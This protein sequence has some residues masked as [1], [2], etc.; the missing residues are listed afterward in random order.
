[1]KKPAL[2]DGEW[3][4]MNLLWEKSPRTIAEMVAALKDDTAWTKATINIMLGRMI[5]KGAV[6][7]DDSGRSKL[8]YPIINKEQAAIYET[9][10]F[11]SK[12]YNGSLSMMIASL[13]GQKALKAEDIEELY[14]VL[15][16][17]EEEV[18]K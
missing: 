3:K 10:N 9:E 1:M 18:K 2:S 11:L 15:N 13:A 6:R 14:K 7:C 17:A 12:V 4:L 16:E 8:F 5:K